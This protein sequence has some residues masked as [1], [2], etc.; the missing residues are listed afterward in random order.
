MD[1]VFGEDSKEVASQERGR[2]DQEAEV[3]GSSMEQ[4]GEAFKGRRLRICQAWR[5]SVIAMQCV[6][7]GPWKGVSGAGRRDRWSPVIQIFKNDVH[8][9]AMGHF[10]EYR[11]KGGKSVF[12]DDE[13]SEDG[14]KFGSLEGRKRA[15]LMDMD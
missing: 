10:G 4:A 1:R 15:V 8:V 7:T 3:F 6:V 13:A 12:P 11:V 9:N 2:L 14:M 5:G